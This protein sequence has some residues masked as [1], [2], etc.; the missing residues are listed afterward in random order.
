MLV[1]SS[2]EKDVPSDFIG[3]ITSYHVSDGLVTAWME[4]Q[5]GIDLQ[6]FVVYNDNGAAIGDV[7]FNLSLAE[8]F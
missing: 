6:D 8:Y 1:F 4:R 3:R 7:G 5:P 2:E